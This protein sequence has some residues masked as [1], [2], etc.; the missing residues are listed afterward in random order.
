MPEDCMQSGR[1]EHAALELFQTAA[2]LL[3]DTTEAVSAV[4]ETVAAVTVDP[5]ADPGAARR[6]AERKLL[7]RCILRART[8]HE[9]ALQAPI[10]GERPPVSS[11]IETDDLSAAGL[12]QGDVVRLIEGQ[13]R[14]GMRRWLED[15]HPALR[16]IFVIR[17]VMG[18]SGDEAAECLR[19]AGA[20]PWTAS[21]VSDAFREALCALAS[22][23][24]H[25]S[26]AL[27]LS[28]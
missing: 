12:R 18:K 4:E 22:S 17:A 21:Q 23:L 27:P 8:I 19:A 11:C 9:E 2:L 7:E 5:C 24:V 15:L 1:A 26:V 13:G 28:A 14:E 25:A 3:G 16:I 10:A 20:G 6:E